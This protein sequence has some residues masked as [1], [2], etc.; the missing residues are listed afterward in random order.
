MFVIKFFSESPPRPI[1]SSSSDVRLW[2]CL[3]VLS[4]VIVDEAH[5]F[6]D[7]LKLKGHQN[8]MTGSKVTVILIT[9]GAMLHT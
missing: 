9:R 2:V 5:Y 6:L 8:C 7:I 4:C 1:Q 3:S